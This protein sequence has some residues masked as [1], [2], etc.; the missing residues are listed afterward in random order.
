SGASATAT[1]TA[2][3]PYQTLT[4]DVEN[5]VVSITG[6]GADAQYVYD[7][8]GKRVKEIE[9][10]ET[11]LYINQYYEKNLTTGV[12]TTYYYLGSK[13]VAEREGT[14]L[15]F[16][17]QDSLN[18]TSLVTDSSGGSLG[19]TTTYPYGD[20]RTGSVPTDEKFT[21]QRLDSTGLYYYNARYY[22]PAIGRFIS[23]DT[24]VPS[25]SNPQALNR[26]SYV[27]N[28]PLK[29][30]DPSGHKPIYD[31]DD[32]WTGAGTQ[33]SNP[34]GGSQPD[35]G[36]DL[37]IAPSQSV[38]PEAPQ[39][40]GN[41]LSYTILWGYSENVGLL[42]T[43]NHT[44]IVVKRSDGKH[45]IIETHGGGLTLGL[46]GTWNV[47]SPD[48][49]LDINSIDNWTAEA[50]FVVTLFDTEMKGSLGLSSQGPIGGLGQ[51]DIYVGFDLGLSIDFGKTSIKEISSINAYDAMPGW[52]ETAYR[53]GRDNDW[54]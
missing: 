27:F 16:L 19:S 24:V 30:I 22:D 25:F 45:Y 29:Y 42:I 18:S 36:D 43:Y 52:V 33:P 11:I 6:N 5:R 34:P 10:G 26:Y 53:R 44:K 13:L 51:N 15:S 3:A 8:D 32:P 37:P 48:Q 40:G 50:S 7:G 49:P 41:N 23:A 54:P 35:P 38:T 47:F 2:I 12:F 21:G 31:A 9:N 14:T 39:P 17:H 1:L 46:G 20:T 28:N 4:W